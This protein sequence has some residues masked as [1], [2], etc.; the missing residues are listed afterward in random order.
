[1]QR[2]R[3]EEIVKAHLADVLEMDVTEIDSGSSMGD[4]GASSLDIV[5]VISLTMREMKVKVPRA[6]LN[7]LENL[8]QL[9]ELLHSV[10]SGAETVN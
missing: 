6:K 7:D 9:V 10:S 8:D 4:L 2:E 3:I 5:E 1:M